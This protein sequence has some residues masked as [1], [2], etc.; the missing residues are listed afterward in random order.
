M[1]I[2]EVPKF[3]V[4]H[5]NLLWNPIAPFTSLE[6]WRTCQ[7][8]VKAKIGKNQFN[9]LL[10]ADVFKEEVGLL[11]ADQALP[12][13]SR[14]PL[15]AVKAI[16]GNYVFRDNLSYMSRKEFN[17]ENEWLYSEMAS[18]D[19]WAQEQNTIPEGGLLIPVIIAS[20]KT[21]LTVLRGDRTAWPVYL[22]IG[23]I[24]KE[25]RRSSNSNGLIIIGLSLK[26][27][28]GMEAAENRRIFHEAIGVILEPLI[29]PEMAG[30]DVLCAD[31][32]TRCGYPRIAS[33]MADY[34][35]MMLLTATKLE[36]CPYCE[37]PRNKCNNLPTGPIDF[38]I[39][40][41]IKDW[42]GNSW[43]QLGFGNWKLVTLPICIQ[44]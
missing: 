37:A 26:L 31:G 39:L 22:T 16:L 11:N 9:D 42:S 36:H 30:F 7:A 38:D 35:E 18:G 12:F 15:D 27:P 2:M 17:S 33:W 24:N 25:K 21:Q 34:P 6:Q 28:T 14:N 20:D 23:N 32:Y 43:Q 44:I 19:W 10:S 40:S 13:Y 29:K 8:M 41:A 4:P 3:Q 5:D 1:L